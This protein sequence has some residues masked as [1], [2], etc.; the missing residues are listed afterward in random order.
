MAEETEKPENVTPNKAGILLREARLAAG[1][2]PMKLCASLRISTAALEALEACQYDRLPGDPYV[3]ALL[4]S[5]ARSIGVDPQRILQAYIQETGK[6]TADTHV[7]PY[8]DVTEVHGL[9]HRKLFFALLAVLLIAMLI[10]LGK[11][12]SS[13]EKNAAASQSSRSETVAVVIPPPVDTLPVSTAL[14][15]DSIKPDTSKKTVMPDTSHAASTTTAVVT[16][17]KDT[18]APAVAKK[19]ETKSVAPVVKDTAQKTATKA[20]E[21][22]TAGTVSKLII[23][24]LRDSMQFRILHAHKAHTSHMLMLGGQMEFTDNDT[25]TVVL[26]SK[27]GVKVALGDSVFLSPTTRRFKVFGNHISYF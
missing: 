18:V 6:K 14:R 8:K 22:K 7:A 16:P 26:Y 21:T 10:I 5:V 1:V 25:L 3:R 13:S 15:P 27:L 19:P 20:P 4:G 11:V 24:S 23:K 17:K 2:D 12:N 9:V